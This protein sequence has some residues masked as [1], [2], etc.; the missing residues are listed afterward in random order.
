MQYKVMHSLTRMVFVAKTSRDQ[1]IIQ[2]NITLFVDVYNIFEQAD[3]EHYTYQK[4]NEN[5]IEDKKILLAEDTSFFRTIIT[6]YMNELCNNIDVA[7]DGVEAWDKLQ[8]N[9]YDLL[10]TDIEMPHMDGF[11]LIEKARADQS[12]KD[13]KIIT[14]TSLSSDRHVQ[15][16][17]DLGVDGI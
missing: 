10:L 14:L 4:E 1:S 15:R 8:K 7:H 12:L 13:L 17:K 16:G 5:V 3:P 2:D 11:E 9:T 6:N